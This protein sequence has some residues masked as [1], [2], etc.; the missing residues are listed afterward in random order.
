MLSSPTGV[1]YCTRPVEEGPGDSRGCWVTDAP[2]RSCSFCAVDAL[3]GK[4]EAAAEEV[5]RFAPVARAFTLFP[6][7][8]GGVDEWV[9]GR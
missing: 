4:C 5:A 9:L 1:S 7:G 8:G 3:G 6:G 2:G